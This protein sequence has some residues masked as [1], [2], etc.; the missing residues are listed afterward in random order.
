M[1]EVKNFL[2]AQAFESLPDHL[3]PSRHTALGMRWCLTWKVKDTGETK[4]KARAVLLG[5]QDPCYEHRATNAPVMTRQ[6]RQMILQQAARKRWTVYKGDVSGAFLQGEEYQGLLH[7]IPTDEICEA[8]GIPPRSITHLRKACYGLV[9]APLQ[10]YRS[11]H[12]FFTSVGLERTWSD[13]CTWVWRPNGVLRGQVSSHVD[14]F[15]FAGHDQDQGW[16]KILEQ[17]K[18][19]FHW[20]DWEQDDFV[21]CGVRVQRQGRDYHLSQEQ[22]IEGLKEIPISLL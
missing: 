3:K 18:Q 22:Y 13:S 17:V 8:M 7:V 12:A 16:Q 5:Y 9:E 10:W 11:V 1:V 20:G 21:Q 14:D 15:L 4:A 6:P 19:R 2:A